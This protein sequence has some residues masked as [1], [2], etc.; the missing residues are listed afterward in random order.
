MFVGGLMLIMSSGY[1]GGL[2]LGYDKGM[3]EVFTGQML[4]H[5]PV[6]ESYDPILGT[7]FLWPNIP[8]RQRVVELVD[9]HPHVDAVAPR[10]KVQ[11][12]LISEDTALPVELIGIEPELEA[13]VSPR[14][15]VIQGSFLDKT[16]S[17][18]ILLPERM[19]RE[20]QVEVDDQI[21]ISYQE[22]DSPARMASVQ[23]RGVFATPGMDSF[24]FYKVLVELE[25]A[26]ELLGIPDQVQEL[27]V[28]LDDPDEAVKVATE[29]DQMLADEGLDLQVDAWQDVLTTGGSILAM[30]RAMMTFMNGAVFVVVAVV[31][32]NTMLMAALERTRDLGVLKAL[33]Y[34]GYHLIG[35]LL[36][37]GGLSALLAGGLGCTLGAG[38]NLWLGQAGIPAN[39]SAVELMFGGKY[40]YPT[41]TW[42]MVLT[43][44]AVVVGVGLVSTLYPAIKASTAEPV[45]AL[46]HV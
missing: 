10:I 29:V 16:R 22:L 26:Q 25:T 33:G 3:R 14:T 15:Q 19:A 30:N 4:I 45:E 37:E 2:R 40:L 8:E 43:S 35:L 27:A 46:R 9:R 39:S 6:A 36:L 41:L 18:G 11:A 13:I 1:Y 23:V 24:T 32:F 31:I 21:M 44:F 20:L 7:M 17:E 28:V 42:E 34:R 12:L 5:V 38:L